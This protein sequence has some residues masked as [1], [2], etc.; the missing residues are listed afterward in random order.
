MARLRYVRQHDW[1]EN[2]RQES[3][4]FAAAHCESLPG[5]SMLV[6]RNSDFRRSLWSVLV[7][8]GLLG[9]ILLLIAV[10][11]APWSRADDA[12]DY[13]EKAMSLY[14]DAANF[15][16]NGAIDLAIE[17]WKKYLEKYPDEPFATKAAH[18]LGVCYMQQTL[19]NYP[20]AC[21]AFSK[22]IKDEKSELREESLVNLGWCEFAGAGDKEK[23]DPKRLQAA[24]DAFR[25]LLKEKP[26]SKYADRALFYGGEAAY[27]LGDA[28]AA[29]ELYDRLVAM[30]A[31]KN[32]PLRCDTFYARGVA[33]EDLKKFDEAVVSYRQLIEGCKE[34]RLLNDARVRVGDVY[35]MQK[36]FAEAAKEFGDVASGKGADVP[37]ALV[38]QAFAFVQSNKPQDAATIY[39]RLLKEFPESPYTAAATLA[40]AQSIYRAGDMDEAAKRFTRVLAQKDVNS[41]TEAAHWL[42]TIALKKGDHK[43]AID[44]AEK[45]IAAGTAGE[46][47]Q[48]LKMDLAEAMMMSPDKIAEAQ[49]LYLSLYE[50]KPDD[51]LAPRALY[52]AAFAAM[53]LGKSK[54]SNDLADKFLKKYNGSPL[55]ADIR[56]IIAESKLMGG[57]HAEAAVDYQSLLDDPTSEKNPQRPLWVLRAGMANYLAGK[58]DDAIKLL[59]KQV[60]AP[61]LPSQIAESKYI[62][63]A[64]QLAAGRGAEAITALQESLKADP[65]WAKADETTLMLGQAFLAADKKQEARATWDSI[66]TTFPKSPRGDQGRY[67]IAQLAARSSQHDVAAAEYAKVVASGL[68][69]SLLPFTLYGLGWNL[70]QAG[71]PAEAAA[72]LERVTK[73]FPTHPIND[74]AKLALGISYRSV[75][76]IDESIAQLQVV[77]KELENSAETGA[78]INRGHALYEL[79]LIDQQQKRP[80][81]A[82]KR[83]EQLVSTVPN[84]PNLDKVIYE[85]SWSLKESGDDAKAESA[86]N[87][88][89]EKYPGNPLTAEAQYFVGQRRYAEEKWKP[90]AAAFQ[91][92]V[93]VAKDKLLLEKSLYRLGWSLFKAED[94]NGSAEAFARQGKEF[95]EGKLI[96][97]ALLMTGENQFKL[98]QYK[99]ALTSYTIARDRIRAKDESAKTV[100]ENADQQIREL[101][102]LH[103]G[104]SAAQL[105]LWKEAIPWYDELRTRFPESSYLAQTLYETGLANQ[106]LGN[107]DEALK[108]FQMVSNDYRNETAAKSRF[109]VGEIYFGKREL[110][111]AIPEFQR[112]MYGYGAEKAPDEM[113]NWQAKSGFEAGRC[114]ELLIQTRTDRDGKEKASVIAKEFFKYVVD[115]HPKHELASK[116]QE[117]L[118][119]LNRMKL[120]AGASVAPNNKK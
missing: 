67:R 30:D 49:K 9:G 8:S 27:S 1:G 87:Q 7:N 3:S 76:K 118:D 78:I 97:D 110:A 23:Q 35:I 71:K 80:G 68:D 113:K 28:K 73:E 84:Y 66:S 88:L 100:S 75:G 39:E 57:A 4:F 90:A 115:K 98:G 48:T 47:D 55:T 86:F 108:F 14:A 106:Q 61:G 116:S 34:E 18:Y 10:F 89:I 25:T 112:V 62:I 91:E 41:A 85:W 21:D 117:R 101:A 77:L 53:Q 60:A 32:S 94:Y 45:Q 43:A 58:H 42:A 50:A 105:Q 37:Y 81:D 17:G 72:P 99:I 119:V 24:L 70:L 120:D 93:K 16:T 79:A 40:S 74:D 6:S 92:A 52:N 46:F 111:K 109:M 96:A 26:A 56:Y 65:K 82:A 20:A 114:A 33:L 95:P 64:C 13:N 22:A 38:R 12:A 31:A 44:V 15:Q 63:G 69:P 83:L 102:F 36:K 54:E 103:G 59:S 11:L 104:Q 2:F 29:V 107:D 51:A 5:A 19:P